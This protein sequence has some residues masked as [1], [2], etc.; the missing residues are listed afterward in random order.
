MIALA[1][2]LDGLHLNGE[3]FINESDLN[4]SVSDV[5]F[6]H[7]KKIIDYLELYLF[8]YSV[9]DSE[10][11]E[12]SKQELG[13]EL[14][15]F[16]VSFDK[17]QS[18]FQC[19]RLL[20]LEGLRQYLN[21]EHV[22]ERWEVSYIEK[23]FMTKSRI[24]MPWGG[25]DI[26][27]PQTYKKNPKTLI[28]D[29]SAECLVPND[30]SVWLLEEGYSDFDNPAFAIWANK[31]AQKLI[32]ILPNEIDETGEVL[33]FNG[34][35]RLKLRLSKNNDNIYHELTNDFFIELQAAV[36]WVFE[37]DR[38]AESKQIL[39]SAE[40]AR[41]SSKDES[42]IFFIREH[43]RAALAG[44]KVAHALAVSEVSKEALKSLADLRKAVTEE[45]AK[46]TE[47]TRQIITAVAGSFAVGL[48]LLAVK[49]AAQAQAWLLITLSIVMALYVAAVIASGFHFLFM[50]KRLRSEWHSRLY[51]FI[52]E[53]EYKRMVTQPTKSTE[54]LFFG[55]AAVGAVIILILRLL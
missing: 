47:A 23:T 29:Y 20:T 18:E 8:S 45:T 19:I 1:K 4:V 5:N 43:I 26:F 40:V 31:A 46:L 6:A 51:R 17:P 42:V 22:Q 7:V 54:C 13:P 38:E 15:P 2:Y 34:P 24:F 48:G 49:A 35:P 25:G 52:P 12:W 32:S 39:L 50:Q 3:V 30:I 53:D 44:A 28:R 37:N 21:F 16:N 33:K 9:T 14:E 36:L 27:T 41:S 55:T 10:G 11:Y